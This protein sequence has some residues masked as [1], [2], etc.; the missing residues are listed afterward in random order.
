MTTEETSMKFDSPPNSLIE[1][2]AYAALLHR[3][4]VM[5]GREPTRDEI[6]ILLY[7][8]WAWAR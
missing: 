2:F 3:R 4:Y 6:A 5:L 7:A 1:P 8:F